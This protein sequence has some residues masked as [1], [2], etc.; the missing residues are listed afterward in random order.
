MK[1]TSFKKLTAMLLAIM[2]VFSMCITGVSVSATEGTKSIYFVAS[3][4]WKQ[5]G[6]RFA[7]YAWT[8]NAE[9]KFTSMTNVEGNTYTAEIAND[10]TQV[11]FVRMNPATT[12]NNWDA[13]NKWNQTA[14]LTIPADKN[15][16]TVNAG[17]W[18]NANGTW[19]TY[20]PDP[21]VVTTTVPVT[22]VPGTTVP[23]TTVPATTTPATD[24][25]I[26]FVASENWKQD[27][28]R[29][30]MYVWGDN[31][32]GKF[33]SM[34]ANE[35]GVYAAELVDGCKNVIFLRMN[36]ATTDNNWDA[37]N[38]WNQTA[39]LTIPAD[40]NCF[41]LNAGE[42][43]KANG[44]WA[45]YGPNPTVPE[46]TVPETTVPETTVPETTVP[47]TTEPTEPTEPATTEPA[48]TEPVTTEPNTTICVTTVPVTTVPPTTAPIV[49]KDTIYFVAS[50]DWKQADARFAMYAWGDNVE[51]KFVS[52]T[53]NAE[54]VYSAELAD[55]CKN[56]IFVR[57]NPATTENNWDNKWNQTTDLTIPEGKNCFTVNGGEW[58]GANGTWSVY[59]PV[60]PTE[61][62]T[63]VPVTTVPDTTVP[64]TTVP[65]TTVLETTVPPV[66]DGYCL[67]GYINGANYGCEEDS[68]TIGD[69]EFFNGKVTATFTVDSYVA[70]KSTDNS[71]WYMTD[72]WQ[73]TEVTSVVLKNTNELGTTADKLFVPAN[74]KVTF[75]LVANADG[76]FTLS[77]TKGDEPTTTV[78]ETTVPET[79]VPDTTAP[80]TP[81]EDEVSLFGDINLVLNE[82][83]ENVY[84]GVIELQAGTYLFNVNNNGTT[85]GGKATYTDATVIDYSAGYKA[86]TTLIVSGGRYTFSFNASKKKLTIKYKPF[87][88]I[89]DLVGDF[90]VELVRPNKNTTVYTGTVRLEAGTYSF[91]VNENGE[92]FGIGYTFNDSIYN[93]PF[94]YKSAAT[95]N[96]TGGIYSV[97]YDTATNELK[98]LQAP[99][100]LGDVS[101]FGDI[102]LP[103]ASQGN[104]VY[105][106]Q[107]ILEPN[108]YEFKVDAFGTFFGNGSA[109]TDTINVNFDSK[110]KAAA[111]LNVTTKMKFTFIF[112]TNT[113]KV[114]V[115]NEVIDTTKVKVSF[116][117]LGSFEFQRSG[118]PA[119]Y[120]ATVELEAG[121]YTFRMDEFGTP[122]GG[123]YNFTDNST[124]TMVYSSSFFAATTMVATGGTYQFT[125]NTNTHVLKVVKA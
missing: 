113:N 51:G 58:D 78:P 91:N 22:T 101:I 53:A 115:F 47:V 69:Y 37:T 57:M 1:T 2:L 29:F 98:V 90:N 40:K 64:E 6:A 72:G 100:G 79:T 82:T 97:R 88:E 7:V 20:N 17:E 10:S 43:D 120:V 125:Y 89:V 44:T 3:E 26:Y 28:A 93:I 104:G 76:T 77:Y 102:S 121:T 96:A 56:V 61:P 63:T 32:E 86:Q 94:I 14:D 12:D 5:D 36:P 23:A 112:D 52:M 81:N 16:F 119:N 38:K 114:K 85:L 8:G 50:A 124:G 122:M 13:T 24:N 95:L 80:T 108:A 15:C 103:L 46:T 21:T 83:D 74:T 73:G 84:E 30:A 27:G 123:S 48:T 66:A 18:D 54:G 60:D 99:A 106:A 65:N 45:F 67:F 87:D 19:A 41:T 92:L 109:F 42:W 33:V 49:T 71:E 59:G 75:T 11:I 111:T 35:E 110:W 25:T 118:A 39:D 34:T 107:T 62:D 68:D 105:S 4:N 116:D 117:D 31:V 55:G 9:G 70:V